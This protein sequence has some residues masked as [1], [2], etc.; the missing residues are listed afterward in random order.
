L[1][2]VSERVRRPIIEGATAESLRWER[3]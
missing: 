2:G 1:K 3:R